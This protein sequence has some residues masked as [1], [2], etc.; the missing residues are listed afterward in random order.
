MTHAILWRSL[1]CLAFA[2]L[3]LA[4]LA[5]FAA[6]ELLSRPAGATVGEPPAEL[7]ARSVALQTAKGVRVAGWFARRS[8]GRGAVLLLHGVHGNRLSMLARAQWLAGLGYSVLLIDLP[9]HGESGGER[10]TFGLREAEGVRAALAFLRHELPGERVGVIGVSLGAAATVLARAQPAPDAVLLESMYPT[11]EE[12][13]ADRLEMRLG[14]PGRWLAPL[15]L[16]QLPLRLS[17]STSELR[18]IDAMATLHAP[19]FI[20]SGSEDRHTTL[21]ETRRICAAAVAP[22]ECWIIE[23]AAHVDLHGFS[24]KAYELRV[25]GFLDR[26]L[27]PAYDQVTHE[28]SPT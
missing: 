19:V 7:R 14:A 28:R 20:I 21:S 8:E 2:L 13:V 22:S 23:G 24:P 9:G 27:R 17:V 25:L 16:V 10:I 11:I 4:A 12:A 5:S 1:A 26:H 18:P 3:V 15:L 6:G